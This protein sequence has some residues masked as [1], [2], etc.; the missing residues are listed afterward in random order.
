VAVFAVGG[1][2]ADQ[3]LAEH[4]ESFQ[5]AVTIPGSVA[6]AAARTCAQD[7]GV[8]KELSKQLVD[9]MLCLNP[10]VL[11]RF[12]GAP[13]IT[14]SSNTFPYV[15]AEAVPRLRAAASRVGLQVNSA[16]RSLAAQWVLYNA[17]ARGCT[18]TI[19]ARPGTSRHESALALDIENYG[20]AKSPLAS[21]GF[22]WYGSDDAVHFTYL[23]GPDLKGQS[24][25]AFQKLWNRNHPEAPLAETSTFDSATSS[26]L[27]A[28]PAGGFAVPLCGAVY[29]PKKVVVRGVPAKLRSTE[30]AEVTIEVMNEGSTSWAPNEVCLVRSASSPSSPGPSSG[31]T[32]PVATSGSPFLAPDWRSPQQPAC[33][34]TR[35]DQGGKAQVALRIRAPVVDAPVQA[36][37]RFVLVRAGVVGHP[38][39]GE[40]TLSLLAEPDPSRPSSEGA[41]QA[42]VWTPPPFA[43]EPADSASLA[44]VDSDAEGLSLSGGCSTGAE[45]AS[46]ASAQ[47][48]GWLLLAGFALHLR[49]RRR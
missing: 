35:V 13:G 12:D 28:S 27:G 41:P 8:V 49:L 7:T 19:T 16:L 25:L 9:A 14:V 34:T 17:Y 6:Q 39:G 45:G 44:N 43:D 42:E 29:D 40:V 20:S 5:R 36:S 23:T 10:G 48:I 32:G 31:S 22:E 18:G 2:V 37:D 46:N 38:V 47:A 33:V 15:V 21:N 11:A 3:E 24:I 30:S 1:C 4:I 26:R